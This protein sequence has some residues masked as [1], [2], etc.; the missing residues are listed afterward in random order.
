M[1]ICLNLYKE[2]FM[3]FFKKHIATTCLLMAYSLGIAQNPKWMLAPKNVTNNGV[4]PATA[5]PINS[6]NGY[7]GTPQQIYFAEYMGPQN[8]YP[9]NNGDPLFF[10]A[11]GLIYNK[12]GWYIDHLMDTYIRNG[13]VPT[14]LEIGGWTELCVVPNPANCQQY[15][16]FT[17]A[18]IDDA[19]NPVNSCQALSNFNDYVYN[20]PYYALID[21]SQQTPGAP[22]GEYGKNVTPGTSGGATAAD[23]YL[24]TNSQSAQSLTCPPFYGDIHYAATKEIS[25][26]TPYRLLFV[27][28]NSEIITYKITGT[29]TQPIQWLNT[30]DLSTLTGGLAGIQNVNVNPSELELYEDTPN[31]KI[32][33]AFGAPNIAALNSGH[34]YL[35]L[36]DFDFQGS[37]LANSAQTVCTSAICSGSSGFTTAGAYVQGIEFS[38]DGNYV[39]F[40]HAVD[41][42]YTNIVE[43][44]TYANAAVPSNRLGISADVSFVTSQIESSRDGNLYLIGENTSSGIRFA[45]IGNPNS[46]TPTFN[47]NYASASYYSK[48]VVGQG[49]YLGYQLP[50]QIDGDTYT[51]NTSTPACCYAYGNFEISQQI[52]MPATN[53]VIDPVANGGSQTVNCT[54][55]NGNAIAVTFKPTTNVNADIIIPLMSNITFKNCTLRFTPNAKMTVQS[56]L[57]APA[58]PNPN[59]CGNGGRLTLNQAVFTVNA[60][61]ENNKMWPGVEVFGINSNG[62]C[63]QG[64]FANSPMAWMYMV[65]NSKIEHAITGVKL[66]S[67][68]NITGGGVLQTGNSRFENN[69]IDVEIRPCPFITANKTYFKNTIFQ[70]TAAL[71]DPTK[72]PLVHVKSTDAIGINFYGCTLQ[73]TYAPYNWFYDGIQSNNSTIRIGPFPITTFKN[74]RIGIWA[75][76]TQARTIYCHSAQ[77]IYNVTGAYL[78]VVDYATFYNNT[79]RVLDN[80]SAGNSNSGPLPYGVGL[81]LNNCTGFTVQG[82]TF[83]NNS[84]TPANNSSYNY[85]FGCIVNNSALRYSGSGNVNADNFIFKNTF[86][87]INWGCQAQNTNYDKPNCQYPNGAGLKYYCN[88]FKSVIKDVEIG[89]SSGAIDYNQGYVTGTNKGF[90]ADNSFSKNNPNTF[91]WEFYHVNT[92]T[93]S[94]P[95][96]CSGSYSP[97]FSLNYLWSNSLN[98]VVNPQPAKVD[99][100][101]GIQYVQSDDNTCGA[102]PYHFVINDPYTDL[103]AQITQLKTAVVNVSNQ[104]DCGNTAGLL[105]LIASNGTPGSVKNQLSSCA[106]FLSDNVL[107]N[108]V[109]NTHYPDGDKQVVLSA[110]SPLSSN[111]KLAV[112]NSTLSSGTKKSVSNQ[113]TGVSPA[114]MLENQVS[115]LKSE[116]KWCYDEI[117]RDYLNDTITPGALDSARLWARSSLSGAYDGRVVR[118]ALDLGDMTAANIAYQSLVTSEGTASGNV[119][120][121]DVLLKLHGKD[122]K[123]ELQN[124]QTL[125]NT[126]HQVYADVNTPD[127]R[128]LAQSLLSYADEIQPTPT[129]ELMVQ[130]GNRLAQEEST[131]AQPEKSQQQLISCYPNPFGNSTTI[132]AKVN[133]EN[134]TAVL[135]VHDVMGREIAKYNLVKG[136]NAIHFS[137]T[138]LPKGML[139]YSLIID[140]KRIETKAMIKG[141]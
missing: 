96:G 19:E 73:N 75:Q 20:I 114:T 85:T 41:D 110:C 34:T 25:G 32:K 69:Q 91:P 35:V 13:N 29:G 100:P 57:C 54:L 76:A 7:Q 79:F 113:Q 28:N 139:L 134:V 105:S 68:S 117:I 126:L 111:V 47:A 9:D 38:T 121:H 2:K 8:M 42:D 92:P 122:V 90:A 12:H 64:T 45:Q 17:A 60:D 52:I 63:T 115:M 23:L 133:E 101:V 33:V 128:L 108:Y 16:M 80:N 95:V 81:Y 77:F 131:E 83:Q 61:C 4:F 26:T 1:Y 98:T 22:L 21:L 141:D 48:F 87:N 43:R 14:P 58:C 127:A 15:Y 116:I 112:Q 82:N 10:S 70:T 93:P 140:G 109:N 39:Y 3:K 107:I 106:P 71:L 5:L 119:K 59:T 30:Y 51:L 102:N 36:M 74:L 104:Y 123:S 66:G 137:P 65:N 136:N 103:P 53:I 89:V 67:G 46:S 11:E 130:N 97:F 124:D 37:Y 135:V 125:Y 49:P 72:N 86:K 50:D 55:S 27:T 78:N 94:V 44:V 62:V 118:V 6:P 18:A 99:P 132:T 129:Y 31:N 88:T 40:T 56:A 24:A 120:V 84:V 138:D